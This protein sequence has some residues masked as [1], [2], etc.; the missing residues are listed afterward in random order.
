MTCS[1]TGNAARAAYDEAMSFSK[2]NIPKIIDGLCE[3]VVEKT[4]A[5]WKPLLIT[6]LFRPMR[7]SQKGQLARMSNAIDRFY[8]TVLTRAVRKPRS[9][10][11]QGRLPIL[12]CGPDSPVRKSAKRASQSLQHAK[13]NDGLHWH[14]ILLIPPCCR[15]K[16]PLLHFT[17]N[18]NIYVNPGCDLIG[19]DVVPL[20]KNVAYAAAYGLKGLAAGR[21]D[22]D[23]MIVLPKSTSELAQRGQG[24][25]SAYKKAR[26]VQLT[27]KR[28]RS[29]G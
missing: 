27:A 2:N 8:R 19:L 10:G 20:V 3:L 16:N 14:G 11:S 6:F 24:I 4:E 1:P 5:S 23:E 29:G 15:M 9:L 12:I 28:V 18:E 17:Q 13:I 26:C 25:G 21:F 7:Q 22:L